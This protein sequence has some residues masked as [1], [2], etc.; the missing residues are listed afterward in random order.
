MGEGAMAYIN[1]IHEDSATPELID[2]YQFISSSY[3]KMAGVNVPTP[4]VYRPSSLIPA[5]FNFG[6][7]QNRVLT[8]DGAHDRPT[9]QLPGI[10]VNFA[11]SLYS[12]CFY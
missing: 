7:V 1:I 5:Y 12:S 8:N 11:V 4:Q 3:S 9:G 2:D 10:L 6:A